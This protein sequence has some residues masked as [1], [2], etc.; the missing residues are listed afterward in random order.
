MRLKDFLTTL[1]V[2]ISTSKG[3]TLLLYTAATLSTVSAAL[4]VEHVEE[5]H[6]LKVQWPMYFISEVLFD[7]KVC[8]LRV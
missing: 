6:I 2:M 1:P 4:V 7:L 8:Y 5:G 3:E